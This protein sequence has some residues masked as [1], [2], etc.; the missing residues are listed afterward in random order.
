MKTDKENRKGIFKNKTWPKKPSGRLCCWWQFL[1]PPCIPPTIF[2]NSSHKGAEDISLP[3]D[4]GFN[5]VTCFGQQAE[6]GGS[7]GVRSSCASA[8]S[9][10]LLP[11]PWEEMRRLAHWGGDD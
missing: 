10:K 3:L 7:D 2:F 5:H 4:F 1:I 9:F 11:S 8:A 6:Q